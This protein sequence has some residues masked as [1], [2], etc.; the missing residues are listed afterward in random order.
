MARNKATQQNIDNSDLANFP[1]G[2]IQDNTGAGNGTPV[3][4]IVYG[5]IHEFFAKLMRLSGITYNDLPDNESNGYQLLE[6]MKGVPGKNDKVYD[7]G[8]SSGKLTIGIKVGNLEENEVVKGKA[9]VNFTTQT[10]LRGSDNQEKTINVVGN[11]LSGEYV[12]IINTSGA[13]Q[14]VRDADH[15]SLD[16]MVTLLSFLKAA[17]TAQ[18]L[19]GALN[20][21][22]T[23]PLGNI[24]AFVEWVN[25]ASSTASLASAIR[26]GLYPMSHFQIVENLG[27]SPVRNTGFAAGMDPGGGSTGET[28]PVSGDITQCLFESKNGGATSWILTMANEMDSTNYFVRIMFESQGDI[29]ADDELFTPVFI[30]V[31]KTQFRLRIDEKTSNRQNLKIHF[32]IVQIS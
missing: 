13:I 32:E 29:N 27:N 2:R 4:E 31:S 22:A 20:T 25:G 10:V 15:V 18:E 26:N 12:K 21:V 9:T 24:L 5:D 7:I 30:P 14:I 16:S 23:T 1:N 19:A 28:F 3:N 17:T 11:F 6:A 8:D